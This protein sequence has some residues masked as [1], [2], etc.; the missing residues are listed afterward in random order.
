MKGSANERCETTTQL[1][2]KTN[3]GQ[4]RV[5]AVWMQTLVSQPI[6]FRSNLASVIG[7]QAMQQDITAEHEHI[8]KKEPAKKSSR[9]ET[10]GCRRGLGDDTRDDEGMRSS[11]MIG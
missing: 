4:E 3:N 8:L 9:A 11:V 6:N 5:E 10:D 1:H 2:P 7:Q